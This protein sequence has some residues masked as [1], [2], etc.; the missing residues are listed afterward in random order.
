MATKPLS[1]KRLASLTAT[2]TTSIFLK[3]PNE[4]LSN[5]RYST[6]NSALL[7]IAFSIASKDV[8]IIEVSS[9]IQIVCSKWA[10]GLW[11]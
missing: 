3:K 2:E 8:R 10:E 11:S 4:K 9:L 7:P 6:C 5:Y 1:V